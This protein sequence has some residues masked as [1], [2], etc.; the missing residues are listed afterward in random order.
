MPEPHKPTMSWSK[1]A[2][3]VARAAEVTPGILPDVREAVRQARVPFRGVR[4]ATAASCQS[5]RP[6]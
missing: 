4:R 6:N 2:A 1:L 3:M 5:P